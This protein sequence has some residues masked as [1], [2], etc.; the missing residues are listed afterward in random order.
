M[1][2]LHIEVLQGDAGAWYW[3]IKSPN[4]KLLAHSET[5]SSRRKATNTAVK[6]MTAEFLILQ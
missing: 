4:G 5:Y 6:I 3:R 2:K 1:K